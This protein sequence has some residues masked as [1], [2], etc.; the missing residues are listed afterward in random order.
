MKS[1]WPIVLT[2]IFIAACERTN[3]PLPIPAEPPPAPLTTSAQIDTRALWLNG[4]D[5]WRAAHQGSKALQQQLEQFLAEPGD[6]TLQAAREAWH[7]A[8]KPIAAAQPFAAL[9]SSNPGLFAKLDRTWR[10]IDVHPVQPGYLDSIDGYPF[11]GIVNDISLTINQRTLRE[12][13]G[14][15]DA[16]EATL[17][18]HVLEFLLWGENAGRHYGDF[19]QQEASD[20]PDLSIVNLPQ[21]RRR[22]LLKLTSVLLT[23]DLQR[24]VEAWQDPQSP[25]AN[26]YFTLPED[27][28]IL[29]WQ[30]AFI[31][32]LQEADNH[33]VFSAE[34]CPTLGATVRA[35]SDIL[36]AHPGL[37][38]NASDWQAQAAELLA[39]LDDPHSTLDTTATVAQL[40]AAFSP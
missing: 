36:D 11:S 20:N 21:N 25:L 1:H 31:V 15:T 30:Q 8:H 23:D 40:Q 14:F 13:H 32:N 33:C 35:L 6:D 19:I 17:G 12:Q 37:V 18:L 2:L 9:S 3:E 38:A 22:D 28:R 4:V 5:Y 26:G 39:A 29:L 34:P 24:L 16:S 10:A 7:M 27:S